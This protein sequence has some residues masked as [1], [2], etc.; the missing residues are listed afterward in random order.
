[1]TMRCFGTVGIRSAPTF[2]RIRSSSKRRNGSSMGTEP[3]AM[4]TFF[5]LYDA[6]FDAGG[7]PAAL[8]ADTSTTFPARRVP[9]PLAHVILFFRNRNSMPLVFCDTTSSLRLSICARSSDTPS[10]LTP[11]S[12]ARDLVNSRCSL[13]VRSAFDGM[14]PTLTQVPPSVL[15]ISTHTVERPS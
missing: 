2:E 15:S 11:C 9:N 14:Q 5:A 7:P 12:A 10:T 6:I 8:A 13:D 1:M 4:M 3:V